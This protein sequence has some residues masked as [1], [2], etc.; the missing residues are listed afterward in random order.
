MTKPPYRLS[1]TA[2]L[3]AALLLSMVTQ[4][5]TLGA[6]F[7]ACATKDEFDQIM[8]ATAR[9]DATTINTLLQQGCMIPQ[10]DLP[11]AILK[12]TWTGSVQVRAYVDNKPV[13][14]WTTMDN[15]H[16]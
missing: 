11:V 13:D 7:P 9:G 8:N 4:A 15:I 5:A 3:A 6:G 2:L 1:R 10:T 16:R 12:R 14:L